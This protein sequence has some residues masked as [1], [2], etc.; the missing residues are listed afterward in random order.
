MMMSGK[1]L[2]ETTIYSLQF[3]FNAVLVDSIIPESAG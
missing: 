3:I 2:N 1:A